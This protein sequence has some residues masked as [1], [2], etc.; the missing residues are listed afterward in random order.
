MRWW[1][2][3]WK[4]SLMLITLQMCATGCA[5]AVSVNGQPYSKAT[6]KRIGFVLQDDVL[7]ES[8]TV[9]VR[10]CMPDVACTPY[11]C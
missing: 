1:Q 8:L 7:Y 6:R 10:V 3:A 2:G 5:A 4:A 9:K 11:D